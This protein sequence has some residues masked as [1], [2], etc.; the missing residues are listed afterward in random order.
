MLFMGG[1]SAAIAAGDLLVAPTRVVLDGPRGT[2]V[3]LNNI[4]SAP[5]T[6]RISLEL[7]RMKS[8]GSLEDIAPESA[9]VAEAAALQMISYAPRR[10]TLP[11]NQPQAIRIGVRA[12]QALPDGEYRAH[13]LFRAIPEATPVTE[14]A[15]PGNG[16]SI[17]ITPIYG[18][19]IPIIVRRGALA[20]TAAISDAHLTTAEGRA[21]LV[22]TLAR[23]GTRSVYGEVR[24]LKPGID[25]PVVVAR[26]IAVYP[27]RNERAVTLPLP[28][29]TELR[30]SATIQYFE[31]SESGGRLITEARVELR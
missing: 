7:R 6:Y 3:I 21:A 2:E 4:G 12:P 13:M 25:K 11:P 23:S 27:E 31:D 18:V 20:A 16:L 14:Q 19:T 24:V 30:G 9:N 26:G 8:D 28:E 29:G 22:F 15:P 5:A 17:A 1:P 10:I